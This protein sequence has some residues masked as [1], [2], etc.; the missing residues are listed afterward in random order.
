ME[1]RESLPPPELAHVLHCVWSLEGHASELGDA[2]QPVL[3]DGRP[4]LIVHLGDAF[5][6]IDGR[7]AWVQQPLALLAG[8]LDRQLMLRPT[9]TIAVVGLRFR[10]CGA[11]SVLDVPLDRLTG[12]TIALGDASRVLAGAARSVRDE[13]ASAD[14][15]TRLLVERTR[16]LFAGAEIDPRVQ[17]AVDAIEAARGRVAM[18]QVAAAAGMTRRHLERRFKEMVGLSP[19]RLARIARF[20]HALAMLEEAEGRGCGVRTAV[21][22]GYADQAHFIRDFTTL[23]GCA[24]GEHLLRR[25][26]MTGFFTAG[27]TPQPD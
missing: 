26:E 14:E 1:Y 7:G 16:S 22:C 20:Q 15:G 6:R 11:S 4:E 18:D 3:P 23:A 25:G 12:E 21:A 5:E 2:M 8:Q 17:R 27:V 13:T 10:A 24:P 19:K 9:G